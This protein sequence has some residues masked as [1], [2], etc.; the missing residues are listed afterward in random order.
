MLCVP[1]AQCAPVQQFYYP[2]QDPGAL[3][4]YLHPHGGSGLFERAGVAPASD[5]GSVSGS[6]S[7]SGSDAGSDLKGENLEQSLGKQLEPPVES[8]ASGVPLITTTAPTTDTQ[9]PHKSIPSSGAL[10]YL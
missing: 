1:I 8:M 3:F 7:G 10:D 9:E 2:V 5:S 4:A 6:D